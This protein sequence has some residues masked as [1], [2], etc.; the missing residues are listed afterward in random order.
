MTEQP[1]SPS[2]KAK[3]DEEPGGRKS[4]FARFLAFVEWLGNLLPHPVTLFALIAIL[5]VLVSGLCGVLGASRSTT[6]VP[7]ARRGVIRAA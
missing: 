4:L 6:P 3:R 5:I 7:P 1:P 2:R